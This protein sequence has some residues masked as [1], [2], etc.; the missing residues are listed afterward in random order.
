MM[1]LTDTK[2]SVGVLLVA[3]KCGIK[4]TKANRTFSK[5]GSRGSLK[6]LAAMFYFLIFLRL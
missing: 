6:I 2:L 1:K 3:R 4:T 5:F